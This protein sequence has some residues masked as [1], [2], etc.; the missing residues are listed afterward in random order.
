VEIVSTPSAAFML[1]AATT[2]L[3][4]YSLTVVNVIVTFIRLMQIV[5]FRVY[6]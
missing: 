5:N 4:M 1:C 3:F 2:L 6:T